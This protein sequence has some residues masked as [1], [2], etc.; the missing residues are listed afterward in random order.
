MF[1]CKVNQLRETINKAGLNKF[2]EYENVVLTKS[3]TANGST[4]KISHMDAWTWLAGLKTPLDNTEGKIKEIVASFTKTTSAPYTHVYVFAFSEY[5]ESENIYTL[6]T[7]YGTGGK[8][9]CEPN[10]VIEIGS[11]VKYM[12]VRVES[13]SSAPYNV[14]DYFDLESTISIAK[15]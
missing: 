12:T 11:D 15:I 4:G 5:N 14:E 9:T 10:D 3:Y 2:L 8:I 13:G 1:R 7:N 6:N